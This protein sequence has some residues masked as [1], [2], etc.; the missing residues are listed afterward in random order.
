MGTHLIRLS[1]KFEIRDLNFRVLSLVALPPRLHKMV[2]CAGCCVCVQ[3]RRT[4][5]CPCSTEEI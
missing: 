4:E 3:V 5:N 1:I 2:S